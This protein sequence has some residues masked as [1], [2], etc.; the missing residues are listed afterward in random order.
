MSTL[1]WSTP[2]RF[3]ARCAALNSAL[4]LGAVA[5]LLASGLAAA[6]L[7]AT[8]CGVAVLWWRAMRETAWR[9]AP[10]AAVAI[11]VRSGTW[12]W[13][14]VDGARHSASRV[15]LMPLPLGFTGIDLCRDDGTWQRLLVPADAMP[16]GGVR[17][18]R[19]ARV[20]R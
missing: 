2:L 9:S 4:A 19:A 18:L 3:S 14:C 16:P 13:T 5:A 6:M 15:R 7:T 17:R 1:D 8:L 20:G 10:H 11:G 12:H